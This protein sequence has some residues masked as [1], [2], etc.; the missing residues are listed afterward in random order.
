MVDVL[1]G[2]LDEAVARFRFAPGL[3]V[4]ESG[5]VMGVPVEWSS[6]APSTEVVD[7]MW[8]PRFG[9]EEPC[10][11]LECRFAR[12]LMTTEFSWT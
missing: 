1:A 10:H 12:G 4:G 3:D 8:Y 9:E 7:G 11:L 5:R 2:Q 6:S